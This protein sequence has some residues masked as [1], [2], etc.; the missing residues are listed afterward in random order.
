MRGHSYAGLITG[1]C[2]GDF[3]IVSQTAV[4]K[5]STNINIPCALGREEQAPF[6]YINDTAYELFSIP[7]DFLYIPVVNS[8]TQLTIPVVVQELS[9]TLF[10][11]AIFEPSRLVRDR[12]INQLIVLPSKCVGKGNEAWLGKLF[13]CS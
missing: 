7:L 11:C 2:C 4:A 13:V 12:I 1:V 5:I 9:G 6:W 3:T 8:Y 10:Q